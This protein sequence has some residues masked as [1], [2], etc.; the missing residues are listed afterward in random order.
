MFPTDPND[1]KQNKSGQLLW[2][3]IKKLNFAELV[4]FFSLEPVQFSIVP[5]Y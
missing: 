5:L 4:S 3:Q 2:I 1:G